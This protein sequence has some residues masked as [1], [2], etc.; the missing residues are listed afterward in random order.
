M[1]LLRRTRARAYWSVASVLWL[2]ALVLLWAPMPAT[3]GVAGTTRDF[4]VLDYV[5]V[6][7]TNAAGPRVLFLLPGFVA[8]IAAMV[9]LVII[10][11]LVYR[12]WVTRPQRGWCD[13]CGYSTRGIAS[14]RCPECGNAL[15]T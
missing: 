1:R 14:E 6:S 5:A 8:S 2:V 10:S 13:E 15:P 3:S 12:R 11:R 7:T 4:G 9:V